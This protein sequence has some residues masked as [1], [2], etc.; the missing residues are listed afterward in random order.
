MLLTNLI[1]EIAGIPER[2][3]LVLDDSHLITETQIHQSLTF[4]LEHMPPAPGGMHLAIA[5]RM[6][7]P[8]PLA[9][10]IADGRLVDAREGGCHRF[11]SGF[12]GSHRFVLDYLIVRIYILR[13]LALQAKGDEKQA[14]ASL[15]QALELAE[16]ENRMATFVRE[17]AATEK[18][19]RLARA[20][21]LGLLG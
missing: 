9:R 18:L 10:W 8:W 5:S 4:L 16:P 7:P 17:G 19:L 21:E 14:L 13:A 15:R 11:F 1:V 3:I 2:F 12:T 6:D 20:K